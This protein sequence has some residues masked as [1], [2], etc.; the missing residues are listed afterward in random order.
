MSIEL[1]LRDVQGALSYGDMI[2][3]TWATERGIVYSYN[4]NYILGE[5]AQYEIFDG[6]WFLYHDLVLHGPDLHPLERDGFVQINYC[7]SGRCELYYKKDKVF[8]VGPEDLIVAV[9]KNKQYRHSFPLGHYKGISIVT[10]EKTLD[11]FLRSIFPETK[12]TSRIFLLQLETCGGYLVFGNNIEMKNIIREIG[13]PNQA[14]FR[15]RAILKF[16]ELILLCLDYDFDQKKCE[17]Y[18]GV[19]VIN[20]VKMIKKEV[21]SNIEEY[22]TLEEVGRRYQIST[23]AFSG[24]FKGVYGKS[25]YKFIKEFRMKRAADLLREKKYS[26]GEIALM[27]GYQ[28][29]SKFSKAFYDIIGMTPLCYR[30]QDSIP[31]LE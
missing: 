17:K 15:E 8:Y 23:K 30:K 6:V 4:E 1:F 13:D 25:Y 16:A 11:R 12:L 14:F 24:C 3:R 5:T 2:A 26:V 20:R 22:I 28:N 9:L 19:Q 31:P 21:T 29:A 10:T 27:V 18:Y 7:I